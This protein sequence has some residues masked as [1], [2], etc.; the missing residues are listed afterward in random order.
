MVVARI[1][2]DLKS[3]DP[4]KTA[5]FYRAVFE[6]EV[7]MDLGW[8]CTL[9]GST[10]RQP[11]QLNLASEGG[12]GTELPVV[13]LQVDDLETVLERAARFGARPEYGPVDEP[14]GVRRAYLRDP[15]GNLINVLTHAPDGAV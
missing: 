4:A 11:I 3:D 2:A 8:I 12:A 6:L 1:V 5:A 10:A 7:A 14:W 15:A 9:A 13:S